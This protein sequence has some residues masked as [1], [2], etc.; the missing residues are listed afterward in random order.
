MFKNNKLNKMNIFEIQY[1]YLKVNPAHRV[2]CLDGGLLSQSLHL[3]TS[4]STINSHLCYVSFQ[5]FFK[6]TLSWPAIIS[7]FLCCYKNENS[8]ESFLPHVLEKLRYF[9]FPLLV[10]MFDVFL[11]R[12]YIFII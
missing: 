10:Y 7:L 3:V 9:Y 4:K 2:R 5:F 8:V 12:N 1:Y 6:L 11:I